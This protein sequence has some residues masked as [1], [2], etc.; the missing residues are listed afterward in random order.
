MTSGNNGTGAVS[1]LGY[2]NLFNALNPA[3]AAGRVTIPSGAQ[4]GQ[5][6]PALLQPQSFSGDNQR[7][8][9]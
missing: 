2:D 7:P 8:L 1:V 9:E 4:A 5:Q 6:D 3:T